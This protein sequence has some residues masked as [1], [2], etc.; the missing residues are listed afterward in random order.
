MGQMGGTGRGQSWAVAAAG[1][2]AA[3]GGGGGICLAAFRIISDEDWE[4]QGVLQVKA[5]AHG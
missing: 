5:L 4:A 2:V 1:G 3:G